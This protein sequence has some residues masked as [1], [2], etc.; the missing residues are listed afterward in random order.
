MKRIFFYAMAALILCSCVGADDQ[1]KKLDEEKAKELE[2]TQ[3]LTND[4]LPKVAKV[5]GMEVQHPV[6]VAVIDKSQLKEFMLKSLDEDYPGDLL[7]RMTE[8]FIMVGLFPD[9]FDMRNTFVELMLEQA[10]AFY[11]PRSKTY[12]GI[13]GLPAALQNP[14]TKRLLTAHELVH[15]LQDQTINMVEVVEKFK[16]DIDRTYANTAVFEG[17]AT[18]MMTTATMGIDP[19][20]M[21]DIGRT[22]RMSMEMSKDMPEMKMLNSVP[23]YLAETLI[24]P[25]AEGAS[26]TQA[27]LKANPGAKVKDMF[28]KWPVSSEQ[29]LHF[30]KYKENDVPHKIDLSG[31]QSVLPTGYEQR[32]V[33][34]LGE[35]EIRVLA[36]IHPELEQTAK[37]IGAG[38]DGIHFATFKKDEKAVILAAS[39]WDSAKDAQ[40]FA[41]AMKL[42]LNNRYGD[43]NF[44]VEREEQ[45]VS[46][47]AGNLKEINKN[48][49]SDFLLNARAVE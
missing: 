38:W 2:A 41:E 35:L 29:I 47:M 11:D 22:T 16:D 10:G 18:V 36:S 33:S 28:D 34:T 37:E 27:Y 31:L 43:G 12:Y 14:A 20:K 48:Q 49:V 24:S 9:G 3:L 26:F 13:I 23:K 44:Q 1:D 42:V 45:R 30:D 5:T 6:K 7:E 4:L 39:V 19:R 15:A 21:P 17:Q 40:E 8:G 46:F 32:F 25:Y